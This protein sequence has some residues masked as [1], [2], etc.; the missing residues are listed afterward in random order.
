MNSLIIRNVNFGTQIDEDIIKTFTESLD[1]A[2]VFAPTSKI[3]GFD[4]Y[5]FEID[6]NFYQFQ[7]GKLSK[8]DTKKIKKIH[9]KKIRL[10]E[11]DNLNCKNLIYSYPDLS[12]DPRIILKSPKNLDIIIYKSGINFYGNGSYISDLVDTKILKFDIN[13]FQLSDH[14]L[15]RYLRKINKFVVVGGYLKSAIKT[16]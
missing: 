7:N 4:G 3:L 15:I 11:I 8:K 13:C 2:N 5:Q 16:I 14:K 6:G 1:V 10:S 12:S 9:H